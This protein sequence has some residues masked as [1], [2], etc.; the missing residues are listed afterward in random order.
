MNLAIYA[1]PRLRPDR[2]RRVATT[3]P[4]ERQQ[5]A[6]RKNN[7]DGGERRNSRADIFADAGEHL[8]RQRRLI[9]AGEK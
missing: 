6:C 7:Q 2:P 5:Q 4:L 1:G 3:K 8:S 9:G